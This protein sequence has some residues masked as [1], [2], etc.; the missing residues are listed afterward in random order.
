MF[1]IAISPQE[2]SPPINAFVMPLGLGAGVI[3]TG[4]CVVGVGPCCVDCTDSFVR[5]FGGLSF[6]DFNDVI[7]DA[8]F[9][10]W[11]ADG[12][13]TVEEIARDGAGAF[14]PACGMS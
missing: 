2:N 6:G 13:W 11:A 1:A 4:V 3:G 12:C 5:F 14:T 8:C 7:F 10:D 9:T